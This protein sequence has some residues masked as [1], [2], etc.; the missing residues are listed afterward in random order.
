[1]NESNVKNIRHLIDNISLRT[2][3]QHRK[4]KYTRNDNKQRRDNGRK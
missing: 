1:M 4:K 3:V 2:P